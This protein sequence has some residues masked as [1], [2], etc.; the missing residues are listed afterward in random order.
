MAL[1][2]NNKVDRSPTDLAKMNDFEATASFI[3]PHDPVTTK[4]Q[5]K[6]GLAHISSVDADE[7]LEQAEISSTSVKPSR[8][9]TGVELRFYKTAEYRALSKKQKEE[10]YEWRQTNGKKAKLDDKSKGKSKD[11]TIATAVAK[12][13]EKREKAAKQE[14]TT[15]IE[16]EKYIMSIMANVTKGNKS[17]TAAAAS[18]VAEENDQNIQ[19]RVTINSILKRAARK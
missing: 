1:V 10:L 9:K 5:N 8:G 7:S 18:I 3:I 13:L 14:A 15:N 12:A 2:R 17:T 4:R 19:G 6:R 16:F 11:K